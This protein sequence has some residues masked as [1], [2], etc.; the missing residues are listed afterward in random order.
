MEDFSGLSAR[1]LVYAESNDY[2]G[3][4]MTNPAVPDE[5]S[6][7]IESKAVLRRPCSCRMRFCYTAGSFHGRGQCTGSHVACC[8]AA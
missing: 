4:H 1:V 8:K 2:P 6:G 5:Y 7:G 3:K